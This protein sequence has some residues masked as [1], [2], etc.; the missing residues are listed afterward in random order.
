MKEVD[1]VASTG[2]KDKGTWKEFKSKAPEY[3]SIEEAIKALKKEEVLALINRQIK[4][5]ALNKLRKPAGDPIIALLKKAV[6]AAP[7]PEAK[8]QIES[9][10]KAIAAKYGIRI[11]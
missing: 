6:A 11:E 5:E 7:T 10:V 8:S 2:S 4:T 3:E 1:I 9:Q